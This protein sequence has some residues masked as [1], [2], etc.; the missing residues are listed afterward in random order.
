MAKPIRKKKYSRPITNNRLSRL[1]LKLAIAI[2]GIKKKN[3]HL[4]EEWLRKF[5]DYIHAEDNK[6]FKSENLGAFKAGDIIYAEFGY[7]VGSE[8]GGR[9][10]AVVIENSPL[11]ANMIM[12]VPLSSLDASKTKSDV[13]PNDAYLG[14][15]PQ[16]NAISNMPKGTKSFAVINQTRALAKQ[17][18]IA[19][20]NPYHERIYI[21]GGLLS[22][23]YKKIQG[24]YTKYGINRKDKESN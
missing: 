24:R 7:N 1:Q 9:H 3:Q 5:A 16:I 12:V 21:N 10:Y 19:P 2:K 14:E 17:R 11:K 15:L 20:T 23:I 6:G 22:L 4:V 13:H 18:I 8:Y